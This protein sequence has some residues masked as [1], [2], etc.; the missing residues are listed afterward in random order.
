MHNCWERKAITPVGA[1]LKWLGLLEPDSPAVQREKLRLLTA[2]AK[3]AVSSNIVLAGVMAA[4]LASSTTDLLYIIVWFFC[5]MISGA[6]RLLA[7][8]SFVRDPLQRSPAEWLHHLTWAGG[9]TGFLWGLSALFMFTGLSTYQ[10]AIGV[11]LICG[12]CAGATALNGAHK[13]AI[14]AFAGLALMPATISFAAVGDP[15]TLVMAG[16]TIFFFLIIVRAGGAIEA[17]IRQSVE[18]ADNNEGLVTNLQARNSILR[19]SREEMRIIADY[20]YAWESWHDPDGQLMWVNSASERVTGYSPAECLS[21]A[22]YPLPIIHPADQPFVKKALEAA[23][24]V[25]SEKDIEFRILHKDGEQRWCASA[26][27]PVVDTKGVARGF[28]SSTR[29]ITDRKALESRLEHLAETD[30]LTGIYNRRKLFEIMTT[31][32]YRATRYGVP[33]SIALFDLDHFKVVNDT[34]G[35]AAGDACLVAFVELIKGAIRQSDVFARLGGEE[36][37][38]LLPE[39]RV[40]EAKLLTDKLRGLTAE[41][42]IPYDGQTLGLTVSAGVTTVSNKDAAVDDLF[43]R[44][45]AALYQAKDEGRNRVVVAHLPAAAIDSVAAE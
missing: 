40:H 2:N 34:H 24:T 29:D 10:I 36:F 41:M 14:A 11:M 33:L 15:L 32:L 20:S 1:A 13:P 23:V 42:E 18:L 26:S 37:V 7:V 38:L 39:T 3:T 19:E 4:T 30:T 43:D 31:E 6:N 16:A 44:A 12:V 17:S 25:M 21:M 5:V 45:D 22:E 9:I 28:R 8:R 35:H 27:R